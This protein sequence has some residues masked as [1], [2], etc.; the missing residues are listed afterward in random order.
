M[1]TR[2]NDEE[3]R[4]R[5]QKLRLVL[6]DVDGV[7]TDGAVAYSVTGEELRRFHVRDGLGVERLREIGIDIGF[8][9]REQ[10][11]MI[12]QRA[13]KLHVTHLFLGVHD[14]G[15]EL[16]RWLAE[17]GVRPDE[18]LYIGDDLDDIDVFRR[19]GE[20][21]LT[22]APSDGVPEAR[23]LAHLVTAAAGGRGVLREVADLLRPLRQ[24]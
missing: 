5:A 1:T 8:V 15:V 9:C 6:C 21:G 17:A 13:R 3:L 19:L 11:P 2:L 7:L 4:S 14:K 24:D 12:L 16:P 23:A 20:V 18:T 10:A 22:A